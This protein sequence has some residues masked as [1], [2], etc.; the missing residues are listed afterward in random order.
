[1]SCKPYTKLVNA[2]YVKCYC[3]LGLLWSQQMLF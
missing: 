1:M 2:V 3:C